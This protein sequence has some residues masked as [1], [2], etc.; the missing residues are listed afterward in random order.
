[1]VFLDKG[2]FTKYEYQPRR[3]PRGTAD[4]GLSG[5]GNDDGE[6]IDDQSTV[7]AFQISL[8]AL[9]ETLQIFGLDSSKDRSSH[10]PYMTGWSS[11][12]SRGT[13]A[14]DSRILGVSGVCH[15]KYGGPGDPFIIV[16]E[17]SGLTT[18]C[19]LVTYEP[20]EHHEIPLQRDKLAQKII[21][22]ASW[23]HDAISE[24]ASTNP[25]RLTITAS[26][27]T[28]P[29]LALSAAG[30]LGSATV[31]FSKDPELLET[32]QV[33]R[34]TRNTYKFSLLSQAARAMRIASKVSIRADDPGVLSLQF[35]IELDD[36]AVVSFVDFRFVPYVSDDQDDDDDDDAQEDGLDEEDEEDEHEHEDGNRDGD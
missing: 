29:Y 15:L 4:D 16:L 7:A 5:E 2:L 9:L 34:R 12:G 10:E 18:T 30:A 19:E 24:L 26:P 6:G 27:T 35:M 32:F 3:T 1:M 8:L 22:R 17:G 28:A 14:L 36:G 21:M 20:D 33:G 31:A 25:S 23:L 13:N 11:F